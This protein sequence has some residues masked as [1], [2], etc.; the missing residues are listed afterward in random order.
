MKKS[1]IMLILIVYIASLCIVGFFGSKI[2]VY[3]K[4]VPVEDIVCLTDG[5]T[6]TKDNKNN[7]IRAKAEPSAQYPE[8]IEYYYETT[9]QEGL[10]IPLIFVTKPDNAST[11]GVYYSMDDSKSYFSYELADNGKTC[12]LAINKNGLSEITVTIESKDKKIKKHIWVRVI[13]KF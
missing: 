3:D 5:V 12:M 8:G 9:Y 1:V 4:N 2:I 7:V 6:L 13:P 10:K 11:G